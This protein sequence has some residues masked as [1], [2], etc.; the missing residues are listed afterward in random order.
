MD[1]LLSALMLFVSSFV[2]ATLL[3]AQ[4]ETLLVFLHIKGVLPDSVLVLIATAGNVL[5]AM[6]NFVLGKYFAHFRDKKWFPISPKRFDQAISLFRKY[7]MWTLLF[8]WLPLIGDALPLIA[9]A[10]NARVFWVVLL[11]TLGKMARYLGV[12]LVF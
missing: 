2:A 11:V 12:I 9:G 1:H 8:S 10:L 6:V 7:G 3:P 5:G 4:S